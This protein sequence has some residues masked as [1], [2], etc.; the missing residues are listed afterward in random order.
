MPVPG[1]DLDDLD[2]DLRERIEEK[3]LEEILTDEDRRRLEEGES[4]LDVLSDEKI[5]QLLADDD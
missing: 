4:L 5:E 2:D 3:K 1:Y